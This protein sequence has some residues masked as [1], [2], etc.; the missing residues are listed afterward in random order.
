MLVLVGHIKKSND[1][2]I[3]GKQFYFNEEMRLLKLIHAITFQRGGLEA[4]IALIDALFQ[5]GLKYEEFLAISEEK[6]LLTANDVPNANAVNKLFRTYVNVVNN[7]NIKMLDVG[8]SRSKYAR[9]NRKSEEH[10]LGN[11]FVQQL[12]LFYVYFAK[13]FLF[14]ALRY[15]LFWS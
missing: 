14:F 4:G 2:A 10:C 15:D 1:R 6:C 12:Y 3:K 5:F 8:Q 13:N 11:L 9:F 7:H